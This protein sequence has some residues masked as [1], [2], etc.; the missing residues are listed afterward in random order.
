MTAYLPI[1]LG[2]DAQQWLRHLPQHYIDDWSDFSRRFIANFQSLFDKPAQPWNLKSIRHRGDETLRSYLKRFQTM[3]NRIPEVAEAAVIEDF[4][5]GSNDLAFV[6]AILQKTPTNVEQLFREADL[7]ITTDE[8]A[9]DLI[10]GTKPAPSAPRRNTNQQT[11][12]R[13]AKRPRE[14]V[15]AT[16][17]PISRSRGAPRGGE[18]T[19]D[20]ILDAQCPYHKDMRHTLRNCRD[21]KHFVGNGR[22]FQPLP[23][24]PPRGGPGEPQQPQQ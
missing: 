5:R 9:Q 14:E 11:D 19:L 21:F 8:R 15:H 18:R 12:K 1:V 2:Q 7:Y 3:R 13:W 10:G 24:P 6:R 16:G 20:D 4:Y 17:P 23:P 22:P